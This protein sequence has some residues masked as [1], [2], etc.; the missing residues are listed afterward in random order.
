MKGRTFVNLII[1]SNHGGW[2]FNSDYDI[3]PNG[4]RWHLPPDRAM[5]NTDVQLQMAPFF[6]KSYDAALYTTNSSGSDYARD[7]RNRILSDAI[8]ALSL[9]VGANPVAY[10]DLRSGRKSNFNMQTEF[11]NGWPQERMESSEKNK[12]H[13]SD[14]S[15]VAY[16]YTFK[17]FNQI[18]NAANLK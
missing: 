18:A 14:V 15:Y 1:G 9:P 17:L 6:D 13:H 10:L 11:E 16:P 5:T 4:M 3:F 12:W 8:P 7:N 2:G